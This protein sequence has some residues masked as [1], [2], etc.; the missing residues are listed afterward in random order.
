MADLVDGGGLA[1]GEVM[2][3]PEAGAGGGVRLPLETYQRFQADRPS[4]RVQE[5]AVTQAPPADSFIDREPADEHHGS[6]IAWK[7][8]DDRFRK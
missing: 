6:R 3:G 7:L 1:F 8:L 5:E 2:G 4:R